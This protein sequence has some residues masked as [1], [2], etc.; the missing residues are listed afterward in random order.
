MRRVLII[1]VLLIYSAHIYAQNLPETNLNKVRINEPNQTVVAEINPINSNP[2][3]KTG[4]FYYWYTAGSI[5]FTQGGYSGKL[6]NGTYTEYYLSKNLKQ[7]G[8][9]K[10]GLKDGIWQSW[11]DDGTLNARSKWKNGLVVSEASR[12]FWRRMNILKRKAKQAPVASLSKHD[13]QD[14]K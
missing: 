14:P 6:L 1:F 12:S 11:N 10:K 8:T 9:Y 2:S 4:L 13:K 7:Q 3:V 5:H